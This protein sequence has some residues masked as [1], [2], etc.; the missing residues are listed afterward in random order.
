[1]R[2]WTDNKMPDSQIIKPMPADYQPQKGDILCSALNKRLIV[3]F[4]DSSEC[5]YAIDH[6]TFSELCRRPVSEFSAMA[7]DAAVSLARARS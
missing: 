2:S 5:Y 1:M 3:H 4:V 7:C 6:G